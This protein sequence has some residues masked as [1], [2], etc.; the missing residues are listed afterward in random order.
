MSTLFFEPALNPQSVVNDGRL[1]TFSTSAVQTINVDALQTGIGAARPFTHIFVVSEGATAYGLSASGGNFIGLN[2][3]LHTYKTGNATDLKDSSGYDVNPVI[4][5]KHYD[6]FHV[7]SGTPNKYTA[8]YLTLT[9]T[10]SNIKIY[11]VLVLN[12]V[13]EISDD[14][15]SDVQF[16]QQLAGIEQVSARGRRSVAP[17]IAGDRAKHR[18]TLVSEPEQG[19][20]T[21]KVARAI[22]AFFEQYPVFVFSLEYERYPDLVFPAMNGEQQISSRYRSTWKAMGRR[23]NFVI[24]EL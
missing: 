22:N 14:G 15:F 7:D 18:L 8:K 10:G 16:N 1:D 13:L 20:R 3:S 24:Q 5:G 19:D 17:G 2:V 9:F 11:Q 12:A 4:N 21:D 6:L 23:S